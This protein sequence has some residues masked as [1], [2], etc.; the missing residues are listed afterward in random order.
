LERLAQMYR[1]EYGVDVR[2]IE[3]SGAAGGLGGAL[4]AL[5]GRLTPGFD[6]VADEV[7]LY[8]LVTAADVVVTGE[9]Y[10]DE[11]SFDGK[12]VGG[13]SEMAAAAGRR[14]VAVVGDAD[15][16]VGDRLEYV[17]LVAEFGETRAR[18]EPQWCVERA[19][20]NLLER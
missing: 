5:G 13:V 16:A 7:D 20:K 14:C 9:G 10:L 1:E 2:D 17:S 19:V 3:G 4:V 18:N 11:E 15:P 8:D 12:V 6:L